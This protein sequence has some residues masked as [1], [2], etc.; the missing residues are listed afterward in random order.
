MTT[1]GGCAF[2]DYDEDG[3]LDAF[4]VNGTPLDGEGVPR[5]EG[6]THHALFRNLRD[7]TFENLSAAAGVPHAAASTGT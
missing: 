4:L 3:W 1:G 6:A 7:G 2:F 5:G